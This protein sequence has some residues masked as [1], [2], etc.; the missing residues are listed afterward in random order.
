MSLN[1]R[2][3][4]EQTSAAFTKLLREKGYISVVDVLIEIGKLTKEDCENWR[5]QKVPYLEKVIH[6]NL[7]KINVIL[8]AIQKYSQESNLKPSKTRYKSWGKGAKKLLR[9]S[10]SGDRNIEEAYST[11]YI[12]QKVMIE[13]K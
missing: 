2:Q 3:I 8:R 1:N 13:K 7:G 5:F 9:F 6:V 4:I 11:H 10:K 12:K